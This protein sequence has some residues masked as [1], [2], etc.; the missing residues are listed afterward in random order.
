M[1]KKGLCHIHDVL[2]AGKWITGQPSIPDRE[3]RNGA[4]A[5]RINPGTRAGQNADHPVGVVA[6][7]LLPLNYTYGIIHIIHWRH[8][9][10]SLE[11]NS[12]GFC[13]RNYSRTGGALRLRGSLRSKRRGDMRGEARETRQPRSTI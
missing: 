11:I 7:E 13:M 1:S 3:I 5:A 9:Q 6:P 10:T 8:V 12:I 2:L 4:A